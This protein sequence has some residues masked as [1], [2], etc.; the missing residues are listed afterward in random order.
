[1][2][3]LAKQS[4]GYTDANKLTLAEKRQ[5][6]ADWLKTGR[7]ANRISPVQ[8]IRT[9]EGAGDP[10]LAACREQAHADSASKLINELP[11]GAI[12]RTDE[13]DDT[14]DVSE[15]VRLKLAG[16]LASKMEGVDAETA[17]RM[18][19]AGHALLAPLVRADDA[20]ADK[21]AADK[22]AADDKAAGR[23]RR[24]S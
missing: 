10:I 23:A 11:P 2:T 4:L 15:E 17:T 19:N 21:A 1:M 20:A 13:G 8:H 3:N 18:A 12:V 5:A 9:D 14:V 22:M 6:Y 7:E 24:R 16:V